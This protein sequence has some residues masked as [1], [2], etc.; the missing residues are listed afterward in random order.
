[1]VE[2]FAESPGTCSDGLGNAP[3]EI[4]KEGVLSSERAR[5]REMDEAWVGF[6]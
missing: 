2:N 1:M 5:K 6:G 3:I 4:P